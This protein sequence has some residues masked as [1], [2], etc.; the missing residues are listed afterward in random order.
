VPVNF[1]EARMWYERAAE[2]ND[3]YSMASL[4][5]LYENGN[6]VAPDPRQAKYWYERAANAGNTYAMGNLSLLV[7]RGAGTNPDPRE[8]VRWA[9]GALERRDAAFIAMMKAGAVNYTRDFRREMQRALQDRGFYSGG[10]DG[11]FGAE[12]ARAIDNLVGQRN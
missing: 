11:M 1:Q 10:L 3:A 9:I 2:K 4:G 6:G 12:T 7:D 8:A 5:W